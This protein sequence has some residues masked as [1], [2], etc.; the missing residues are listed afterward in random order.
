MNTNFFVFLIA[1]IA[2]IAL[3]HIIYIVLLIMDNNK[4]E[5]EKELQI[6]KDDIL[7]QANLLF[8]QKK[9]KLVEKLCRRYLEVKPDHS[10]LRFLLAKTL[11][12]ND[13]IY[14][15]IKEGNNTIAKSEKNPE[16]MQQ[17]FPLSHTK[18]ASSAYNGL[19]APSY[20]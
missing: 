3:I 17:L 19:D 18:G 12:A 20:F 6:S 5:P 11:Y 7:E 15:A 9:Y 10:E 8:K 14:E 1:V 13:N 16:D 2:A 4:K